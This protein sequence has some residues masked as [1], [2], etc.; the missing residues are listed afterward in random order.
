LRIAVSAELSAFI[1]TRVARF[2][3]EAPERLRWQLPF[4]IQFST[5]PLYLG[6]TETIGIR[7]DGEVVSWSTEGEYSGV[8]S[9]DHRTWVVPALVAGLSWY[10]ELRALLPER[11]MN[12]SDCPCRQHPLLASGKFLCGACGGLGWLPPSAAEPGAPA[13]RPGE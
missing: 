8:R 9:V 6:W 4:V 3:V 12:A 11:P 1:A 2:A 13:D 7:A 5:I 10:P